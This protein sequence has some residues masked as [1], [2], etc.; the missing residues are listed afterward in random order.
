MNGA[1]YLQVLTKCLYNNYTCMVRLYESCLLFRLLPYAIDR[2]L[3]RGADV[4]S[5]SLLQSSLHNAHS[6]S[7]D[8]VE[9]LHGF[10]TCGLSG[11]LMR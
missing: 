11:Y 1:L 6:L 8:K 5:E 4:V 10:A 2:S 3:F 9:A 7:Y